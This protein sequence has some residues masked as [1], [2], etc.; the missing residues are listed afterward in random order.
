[1]V[2]MTGFEPAKQL[3]LS[4]PR[5]PLRHIRIEP[6]PGIEPRNSFLPRRLH[7]TWIRR[8]GALGESRTLIAHKAQGLNLSAIPFAYERKVPWIGFEPTFAYLKDRS[9][10]PLEDHGIWNVRIIR[11]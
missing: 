11:N 6:T 5:L 10:S 3:G 4:K 8:L 2:R 9:P 7:T 1:M